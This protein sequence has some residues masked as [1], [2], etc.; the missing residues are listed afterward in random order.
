MKILTF[1][2]GGRH[3]LNY[4][5]LFSPY[6]TLKI[7]DFHIT[8]QIPGSFGKSQLLI[9]LCL[10]KLVHKMRMMMASS[11]KYHSFGSR[12]DILHVVFCNGQ[13]HIK[14]WVQSWHTI[15]ISLMLKTS[16][17]HHCKGTQWTRVS[18]FPLVSEDDPWPPSLMAPA[19]A[20]LVGRAEKQRRE[21]RDQ[22]VKTPC[23]TSAD[24]MNS[25]GILSF[26]TEKWGRIC[27]EY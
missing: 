18:P 6:K 7:G 27:I 17:A 19:F 10:N 14:K 11:H 3:V 24:R 25:I 20:D 8:F 21:G 1:L 26:S 15:N 22:P 13:L 16:C 2:V 23:W 9:F 4:L 5:N 12:W